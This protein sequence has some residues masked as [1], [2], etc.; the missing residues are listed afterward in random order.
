[1]GE[2]RHHQGVAAA[3]TLREISCS[4]NGSIDR[5]GDR[6]LL[7]VPVKV[8]GM[9]LV[10]GIGAEVKVEGEVEAEVEAE[11]EGEVEVEVAVEVEVTVARLFPQP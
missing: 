5:I 1:M 6:Y 7:I 9:E 11:V 10:V 8:G 2:E 4:P 3:A